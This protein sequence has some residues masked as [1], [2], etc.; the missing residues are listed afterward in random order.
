MKGR[1]FLTGGTGSL[2]RAILARAEQDKWDCEFTVYSRDEV[3]QGECKAQYPRHRYVLGDVRDEAAMALHMRGHDVVIH[4]GAYKQVPAAEANTVEAIE[5]NVLGS[6]NVARA[7]LI[8]DV[9][10]V[11]GISTDKACSP[12]NTYG[13]S[14]ALMEKA[15]AQACLWGKTQ[16]NCCRYG[17]V[18]GSRGSIVPLFERQ[19][20]AGGPL[21]LTD[22]AMTRFWL[23]LDEA[24]DIIEATAIEGIPG[25]VYVPKCPASTMATLAEAV[26]PECTIKVIGT[27]PGEKT[28]EQLLNRTEAMN[29]DDIGPAFRIWPAYTGH[30]GSL[31]EGYEYRSDTARQLSP[32]ELRVMLDTGLCGKGGTKC[33]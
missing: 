30:R 5:T 32:C 26:A 10:R 29:A 4:T 6:C 25:T 2:G 20:D 13:Q 7:A 28:H 8:A 3:K 22:P 18:L 16:F 1:I 31:R 19:R 11:I 27:R 14:K 9:R 15:F 23:T 17:N 21:T 33:Q 12:I 24:V